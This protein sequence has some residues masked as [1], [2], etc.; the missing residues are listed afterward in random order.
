MFVK[1]FTAHF[2]EGEQAI[3]ELPHFDRAFVN[4]SQ[5]ILTRPRKHFTVIF[6]H[7]SRESTYCANGSAQIMRDRI[8]EGFQLA[9]G[10]SEFRI[11]LMELALDSLTIADVADGTGN[12]HA[13]FGLD[14]AEADLDW[15]LSTVSAQTK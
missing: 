15:K 13:F 8:G 11:G 4:P 12:Q 5:M 7:D 14:G 1:R 6:Q 9:N 10:G 2:G 3:N